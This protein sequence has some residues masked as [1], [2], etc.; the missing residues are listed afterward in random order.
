MHK[1]FFILFFLLPLLIVPD[2]VISGIWV[3]GYGHGY[4]TQEEAR[5]MVDFCHEH[6]I[7]TIFIQVRKLGD[8][9]YNSDTEP[10]ATNISPGYDPLQYVLDLANR[11]EPRISIHAWLVFNK[12]GSRATEDRLSQ[13]H[14]LRR[15]PEWIMRQ[16]DG[17]KYFDN[18]TTIWIDPALPEVQKYQAEVVRE[19]VEKYLGIDGIHL[20]YIRYPDRDA[21]YSEAVLRQYALETGNETKPHPGDYQWSNWRREKITQQVKKTY[22]TIQETNPEVLLSVAAS[23]N[24]KLPDGDPTRR[25]LFERSEPYNRFFQD[26][27]LWLE[28]EIID[29]SCLMNYKR[30]N[31]QWGPEYRRWVDFAASISTNRLI[32]AGQGKF[33][34]DN[35]PEDNVA[36]IAYAFEKDLDGMIIYNYI[37]NDA[38]TNERTYQLFRDKIMPHPI[39]YQNPEW[40]KNRSGNIIGGTVGEDEQTLY[41]M[42][43]VTLSNEEDRFTAVSDGNGFF[44]F[45]SIPNGDYLLETNVPQVSRRQIS[46]Q[47]NDII[48]LDITHQQIDGLLLSQGGKNLFSDHIRE[49]ETLQSVEIPETSRT[50]GEDQQQAFRDSTSHSSGAP[51]ESSSTDIYAMLDEMVRNNDQ[52]HSENINHHSEDNIAEETVVTPE[53]EYEENLVSLVLFNGNI[54]RGTIIDKDSSNIYLLVKD[55]QMEMTI[56]RNS[57][58]RID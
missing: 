58:K 23:C 26:W 9:Y 14:I 2:T 46:L 33:L 21:G 18:G 10:R 47:G 13:N 24:Y 38:R 56:P 6:N 51:Y 36:Q 25:D 3:H 48:R 28:K 53:P 20:D 19:I 41:L 37:D 49:S 1:L 29:I 43:T 22:W 35:T 11:K 8:T 40:V 31:E 5:R 30:E 52:Q 15:H 42:A 34:N 12:V 17:N 27:P 55:Y 39:P 32:A 44:L 50:V 4:L 7:N 54:I 57:V 16:Q 45:P